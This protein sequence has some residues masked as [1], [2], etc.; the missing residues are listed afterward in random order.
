MMIYPS[1]YDLIQLHNPAKHDVD[2]DLDIIFAN[3]FIYKNTMTL[4]WYMMLF[5]VVGKK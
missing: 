4:I 3:I 5:I 1:L 2:W